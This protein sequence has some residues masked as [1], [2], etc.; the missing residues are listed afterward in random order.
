MAGT[1]VRGIARMKYS[2]HL[3]FAAVLSL[4]MGA[5][6][7]AAASVDREFSAAVARVLNGIHND[8]LDNLTAD[9]KKAFVRCAQ[10]IMANAPTA[11]KEYVLAAKDAGEM[12]VRFDEVALD[13][14]AALKQRISSECS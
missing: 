8:F 3:A 13:N 5:G 1:E 4:G 10:D 7:P 11:R 14:R 12:R 9:E 2:R 6:T